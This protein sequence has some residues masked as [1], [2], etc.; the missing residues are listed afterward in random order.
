MD[1]S[2]PESSVG[3]SRQEYQSG[4]PFP[5]PGEL[6]DPEIE[7]TPLESP[8][9]AGGFF[10]AEPSGKPH[11][12]YSLAHKRHQKVLIGGKGK[13]KEEERKGKGKDR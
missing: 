13:G 4:L 7:P 6:P 8:A 11:P 10:T 9:L 5:S 2:L 1:R 3:F 12:E